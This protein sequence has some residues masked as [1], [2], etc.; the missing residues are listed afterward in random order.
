MGAIVTAGELFFGYCRMVFHGR[1]FLIILFGQAASSSGNA[2][3]EQYH[4][5][6]NIQAIIANFID[7][8]HALSTHRFSI[9]P[10]PAFFVRTLFPQ[11]IDDCP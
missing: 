10:V 5:Y 9:F 8:F 4:F 7:H 1:T 6:F 11:F 3:P 2:A